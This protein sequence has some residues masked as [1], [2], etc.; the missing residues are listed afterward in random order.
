MA[1][2][3]VLAGFT[4]S[5]NPEHW[6]DLVDELWQRASATEESVFSSDDPAIDAAVKAT[7]RLHVQRSALLEQQVIAQREFIRRAASLRDAE[8]PDWWQLL[9]A[10]DQVR[11]WKI[12]GHQDWMKLVGIDRPTLRRLAHAVPR[13]A[14][15]VWRGDTGWDGLDDSVLPPRGSDIAYALFDTSGK[16]VRVGLT[17]Q[18]RA[19]VKR[20][21]RRGVTWTAWQAWSCEDRAQAV[22]KRRA[23][24]EQYGH[25]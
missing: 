22:A 25:R 2:V 1:I 13:N 19:H 3:Q 9:E 16:A 23:V 10:Y 24:A 6:L 18:F 7:Q 14:D 15:G 21:H 17:N 5:K 20:L 12:K 4:R 11:A 8:P